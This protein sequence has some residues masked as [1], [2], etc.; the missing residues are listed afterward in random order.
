MEWPFA[1]PENVAVVTVRQILLEHA[2]ILW[3]CHDEDDGAWQFLPGDDVGIEDAML[4]CLRT[5]LAHDPSIAELADL[6]FDWTAE[7]TE[8]GAPW[9]RRPRS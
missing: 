8:I 4:V 2:P 5:V 9:M 1:D 7:R 3:V 6:P